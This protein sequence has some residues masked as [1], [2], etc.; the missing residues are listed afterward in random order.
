[1]YSS[2]Y[3]NSYCL[4]F[5]LGSVTKPGGIAVVTAWSTRLDNPAISACYD[6]IEVA[7]QSMF[8]RSDKSDPAVAAKIKSHVPIPERNH[9]NFVLCNPKLFKQ[10]LAYAGFTSVR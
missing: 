2:T 9:P 1:M 7:M 6:A 4:P 5:V 8:K 3:S 10:E